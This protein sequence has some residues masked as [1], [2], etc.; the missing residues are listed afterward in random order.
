[1]F[2]HVRGAFT[3]ARMDREGR[4]ATAHQGTIFL[5][6]IGDLPLACQVKLL[7]VLQEGSFEIVGSSH[8]RSVDVRVISATNHDLRQ[9][10]SE[11]RFREDLYYRINLITIP[12]PPLRE[13]P[14]D[15]ALLVDHFIRQCDL[16]QEKYQ[17]AVTAAAIRYLSEQPW[18]GNVRELKNVVE[19]VLLTTRKP[20]LDVDDFSSQSELPARASDATGGVPTSANLN[21]EAIELDT[22][23]KALTLHGH[24]ISRV[25]RALGLSRAALY[26]RLEKYH[27]TDETEL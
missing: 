1:M 15:V 8:S 13:R 27:L 18:P 6:E 10:I 24:N 12:V 5:D 20:I 14:E 16:F 4:F 22:I 21:L 11:G 19:R 3:D 7:R 2:G 9:L 26:R 23:K 17:P 25:A